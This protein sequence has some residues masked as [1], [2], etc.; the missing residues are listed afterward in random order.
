MDTTF[1]VWRKDDKYPENLAVVIATFDTEALANEKRDL[2]YKAWETAEVDKN[3]YS[4]YV[5]PRKR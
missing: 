2:C 1:D 3:R 5:L 4:F